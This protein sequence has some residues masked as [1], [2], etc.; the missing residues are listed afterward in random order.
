MR[1]TAVSA[2]ARELIVDRMS[3]M[4]MGIAQVG[5]YGRSPAVNGPFLKPDDVGWNRRVVAGGIGSGAVA[6]PTLAVGDSDAVCWAVESDAALPANVLDA[7]IPRSAIVF[8]SL[9]WFGCWTSNRVEE[10]DG[11]RGDE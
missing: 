11:A 7:S 6:F 8:W 1:P 9:D 10:Q 3:L 4:R 5:L 2:S